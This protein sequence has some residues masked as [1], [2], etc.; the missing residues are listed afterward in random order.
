MTQVREE[1]VHTH[2]HDDRSN[3]GALNFLL[4]LIALIVLLYVLIAYGLPL[5]QGAVSRPAIQVPSKVDVNVN[6]K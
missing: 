5:L 1:V 3:S 2:V 6:Q 4:G